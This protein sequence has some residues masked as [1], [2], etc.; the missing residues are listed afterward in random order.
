[1][2]FLSGLF[3]KAHA[4]PSCSAV[5][6]AAG[7]STRMGG[8]NKLLAEINGLPVLAHTLMAFEK[9]GAVGEIVVVTRAE[10]IEM[11]AALCKSHGIGKAEKIMAGGGTRLESVY[12]GVFAVSDE[13][14]Y[15]A[16]HD[17]ARPCI[18]QTV[19][20]RALA[21]AVKSHAAAP[22]IPV[23][24]TLKRVRDGV[25]IETIDREGLY[26]VQTPQVFSADVIKAALTKARKKS[27]DVT[28]DCMAAELI[29]FPVFITEGSVLNVK[30]TTKDD[31]LV[32][33]AILRSR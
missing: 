28:D 18:E 24:P 1:M 2:S 31:L 15:I 3:R 29:G 6:A 10:D 12:N 8:E 33:E 4:P 11:I 9:C 23:R 19:I 22:A 30:I 14:S 5:I 25:I 13:A 27:V 20:E 26:E 21:A 32:A 7:A 17:G 16:I